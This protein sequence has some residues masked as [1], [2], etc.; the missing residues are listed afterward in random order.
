M[1]GNSMLRG[2]GSVR[3]SVCGIQFP[4]GCGLN[5]KLSTFN[6]ISHERVGLSI[7][8]LNPLS[9]LRESVAQQTKP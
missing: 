4:I 1:F 7:S 5:L 3:F 2:K 9:T 6:S 8:A